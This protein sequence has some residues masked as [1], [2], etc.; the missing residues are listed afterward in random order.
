LITNVNANDSVSALFIP[1][2]ITRQVDPAM[3]MDGAYTP[4]PDT[5]KTF[6]TVTSGFTT[7]TLVTIS[8]TGYYKVYFSAS[9]A[10]QSAGISIEASSNFLTMILAR[11][12]N[13]TIHSPWVFLV[14]GQKVYVSASNS[15]TLAYLPP[16]WTF[17]KYIAGTEKVINAQE[18]LDTPIPILVDD[19]SGTVKQKKD[20][21][22]KYL[23]HVR[24]EHTIPVSGTTATISDSVTLSNPIGDAADSVKSVNITMVDSAGRVFNIPS[25]YNNG[26]YFET[27]V[28]ASS[29]NII[30]ATSGA[31]NLPIQGSGIITSYT[32]KADIVYAQASGQQGYTW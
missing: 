6:A 26:S 8:Q 23:W 22:G 30:V 14:A 17:V 19:G 29:G 24:Y 16:K 9:T 4:S 25:Y 5:S 27:T 11:G 10:G 32:W 2:I 12:N 7:A 1:S 18:L 15:G 21:D 3:Q 28:Y 20:S 31:I 13:G